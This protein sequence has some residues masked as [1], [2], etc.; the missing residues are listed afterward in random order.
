MEFYQLCLRRLEY[1]TDWINWLEDILFATA[2]IFVWIFHNDCYCS[3]GWQ[4]QVGVFAV[5]LSWINLVL[6]IQKLPRTGIYVVMFLNIF[7][8]FLK[9]VILSVLLVISFGLAFYMVFYKPQ[10]AVHDNRI[11][12][13]L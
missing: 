9:V 6:F 8:T 12:I 13:I 2:V 5:F 3:R 7:Y 10:I 4:W 11:I 1:L